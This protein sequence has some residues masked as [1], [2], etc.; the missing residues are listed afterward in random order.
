MILAQVEHIIVHETRVS[1]GTPWHI[2]IAAIAATVVAIVGWY[3][4]HRTSQGRDLKNWRRTTLLEAVSALVESSIAR[5]DQITTANGLYDR[6]TIPMGF[7]VPKEARESYRKMA[8]TRYQI[9]I[10]VADKVL[11]IADQIIMLHTTSDTSIERLKR[12]FMSPRPGEVSR[13]MTDDQIVED[14]ELAE[15]NLA[16]L[17][18][19]HDQIIRELQVEIGLR[20]GHKTTT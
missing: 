18:Q 11:G 9:Q 7:E 5:R 15:I 2:Y 3:V 8:A 17:T 13:N 12:S 4:V 6:F 1:S 16:Q 20:K 19:Y 14:E 10:C